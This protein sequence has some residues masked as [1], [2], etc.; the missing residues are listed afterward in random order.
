MLRG[1]R[2][3]PTLP[4]TWSCDVGQRDVAAVLSKARGDG[5]TDAPRPAE[6]NGDPGAHG[7]S[8]SLPVVLRPSML[9]WAFAASASGY[10]PP[11]RTLSFPSAI[12][13]N[14]R[15]VRARS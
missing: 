15:A 12:Q 11:F 6:D 13:S 10:S 2:Y 7:T 9:A 3:A 1:R 4:P 5:A 8:N 14:S